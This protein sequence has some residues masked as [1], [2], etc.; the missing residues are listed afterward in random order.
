MLNYQVLLRKLLI[1]QIGYAQPII[2]V[3][4]YHGKE[5]L[6]WKKSL[7][8]EDFKSFFSKIPI[9]SRKNMLNYEPKIINTQDSKIR[10]AY[11][12]KEFKGY[13][14]IKLLDEIWSLKKNITSSKVIEA[15]AG[16]EDVLKELKGQARKTAELRILEYLNDNTDLSLKIWRQ[17]EKLLI[18]KGLLK[19]GG[20]MQDVREVIKEKGVWEGMKKG[21]RKGMLKGRQEGRQEVVLNML[22][23][24]ADISFI[25]KV[26]GLSESAI[27][28]L[29]NNS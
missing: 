1:Q 25:A 22:K 26:T 10:K 13:G 29:K 14:V 2:P 12:S 5:P 28:K 27:K 17:A 23:E 6:K 15:Y 18:E 24:R 9:E 21:I 11:K 16:F 7:Q 8:E 20:L 19:Q 4:F 3:L